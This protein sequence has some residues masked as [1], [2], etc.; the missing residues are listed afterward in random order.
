MGRPW[1]ILRSHRARPA[2][3]WWVPFVLAPL[4]M[5]GSADAFLERNSRRVDPDWWKEYD[6]DRQSVV[7]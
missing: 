5:S 1:M 7:D 3:S 6:D 4:I 2:V